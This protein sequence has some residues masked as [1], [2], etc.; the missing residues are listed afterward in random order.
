MAGAIG[1]I[2][3]VL[4]DALYSAG[5]H[6][7][8]AGRSAPRLADRACR[9]G[10]CP[11]LSFDAYDLAACAELPAKAS[12]RLQGLD[13][14]VTVFGQWPSGRSKASVMRSLSI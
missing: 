11:A 1:V 9:W 7:A 13:A 10:E 4:A 12:Q 14:V 8:I 6:L 5:A 3:T 2:G